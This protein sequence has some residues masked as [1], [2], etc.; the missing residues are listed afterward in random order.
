MKILLRRVAGF[1]MLPG[2]SMLASLVLLPLIAHF[3]GAAG[4]TGMALGQSVGALVSLVG[5]LAW[6]TVGAQRIVEAEDADT[7]RRIFAVSLMSRGP[8]IA[9]LATVAL[10]AVWWLAAPTQRLSTA[11][12]LTATSLNGLT[13]SWYYAGTGSPRHLVVNEG[14]TRFAGYA[15]AIPAV[16]I[17][18]STLSY[19]ALNLVFVIVAIGLNYRTIFGSRGMPHV[20]WAQVR[21][22]YQVHFLGSLARLAGSAHSYLPTSLLSAT[23]PSVVPLFTAID[24]V[25]KSG[26]NAVD[27]L[28]S[29]LIEWMQTTETNAHRRKV[30]AITVCM[31]IASLVFFG[32][33]L[34]GPALMRFL[35][36]GVV[37]F[38]PVEILAI[39]AS[40]ALALLVDA[41]ELLDLV[42][43]HGENLVF[44]TEL[45]V[46]LAGII[47]VVPMALVFGGIGAFAT[48]AIASGVKLSIF[49]GQRFL[50]SRR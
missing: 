2:L 5:G 21:E 50:E 35:Y 31:V 16:I 4:W 22:V 39:G 34:I 11:C 8:L 13:A 24:N 19:A 20:G 1:A 29:A 42:P 44:T 9:L 49:A 37:T 15:L 25:Y 26:C 32:W 6:P 36:Q 3:D 28:P 17:S 23:A 33:Q 46:S 18:N 10:P 48:Y 14:I 30:V 12:F 43:R 38:G 27:F 40:V 47:A 7:R 41:L 45:V